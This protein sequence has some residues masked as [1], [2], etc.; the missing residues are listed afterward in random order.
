MLRAIACVTAGIVLFTGAG[1]YALYSELMGNISKDY[2]VDDFRTTTPAPSAAPSET[3]AEAGPADP[4]AGQAYNVLL[5][6]SDTREGENDD[7]TGMEGA[8]ADTTILVHI[9]AD[10]SRVEAVSIPRDTLVDIPACPL[11][12]DGSKMSYEQELEMFNGAFSTGGVNGDVGLGALCTLLTVEN[13]TGL[14]IDDYAVVDFAGFK[15]MVDS[16]GGVPIC[17]P[18]ALDSP[19]TGVYL[20]PGF[21]V[22]DGHQ[23]LG[24]ARDRKNRDDGSDWARIGHQ[25]ELLAAMVRHVM[26]K[27]LVTN[28][29]QLV[30]FLDAVTDSLTMSQG[31]SSPIQLAGLATAIAPVGAEGVTFVT[32]PFEEYSQ[33][34]N[35]VVPAESADLLWERLRNDVPINS[36]QPTDAGT[37]AGAT[38]SE[39]T[40]DASQ[41][42][43]E[44]P[45]DEPT[46]GAT[47]DVAEPS[48]S[49]SDPW[50]VKTGLTE[51]AC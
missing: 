40:T 26:S 16:I 30:Q 18:E 1:A 29:L 36:A 27:N 43:S 44:E 25:Q 46:D 28:S 39:G 21:Q 3:E 8:R 15:R 51:P 50:E 31:L 32:M 4:H 49:P 45:S 10:R 33:N 9:P 19:E 41:A 6:G 17:V 5:M 14:T 47:G 12:A 34:R 20:E 48:P 42:A 11:N 35:R 37:D 23:A 7:G 38:S 13:M 24:Y 22:L 2:A